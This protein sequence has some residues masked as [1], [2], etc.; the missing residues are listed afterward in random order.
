MRYRNIGSLHT[1]SCRGLSSPLHV[2]SVTWSW[3]STPYTLWPFRPHPSSPD[4]LVK[5]SD[6]QSTDHMLKGGHIAEWNSWHT[7]R[8]RAIGGPDR[9]P[10]SGV[11][12]NQF[13]QQAGLLA[14]APDHQWD[15]T[16]YP[17][18]SWL[19][20]L[21]SEI[22]AL[23]RSESSIYRLW[24]M[25]DSDLCNLI[26]ARRWG[27][28][29]IIFLTDVTSIKNNHVHRPCPLYVNNFV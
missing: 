7:S 3:M 9:G 13:L 6:P 8:S 29:K 23:T 28:Q 2:L 22:E 26:S 11:A 17:E 19:D 25:I 5:I 15:R 21:P 20:T 24:K 14:S 12:S 27:S 16:R 4:H 18:L 10:K 1:D